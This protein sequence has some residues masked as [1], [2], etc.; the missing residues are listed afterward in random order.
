MPSLPLDATPSDTADD[1]ADHRLPSRHQPPVPSVSSS[2]QGAQQTYGSGL[3]AFRDAREIVRLVQCPSCSRLLQYPV[4]LPCGNS[5]CQQCLP[6][7]HKRENITY[8]N[9]P[10]RLNGFQCPFEGCRREHSLADCAV[11]IML[12][13]V[14]NIVEEVTA[15]ERTTADGEEPSGGE[16]VGRMA[17]RIEWVEK[18]KN[19]CEGRLAHAFAAAKAGQLSYGLDIAYAL[20]GDGAY[21]QRLDHQLLQRIKEKACPE[22]EC[23]VCCALLL[24]PVTTYC[25]HTFCRRCLER[26]LDHSQCCPTCRRTLQLPARLPAQSSNVHLTD[27]LVGL[28]PDLLAQRAAAVAIEEKAGSTE[29]SLETPI[30]VC[31]AS[32][33]GMPTPL[34]I[35]EPRYRLMVRRAWLGNR[36]FGMVLPNRSGE[37]QGELGI[38]SFM[39][40][41][42][43]LYMQYMDFKEDGR[44]NIWTVGVYKF[45]I[46]R[47]G[48]R[49]D[50]I[51]ADIDRLDDIPVTDE[52]AIEHM[53]TSLRVMPTSNSEPT[54]QWNQLSTQ[55]MLDFCHNFLH[56]PNARAQWLTPQNIMTFGRPPYDAAT[57]P[58]WLAAVMPV[59]EH[60]KYRLIVSTNVRERMKI[61]VSWIKTAESQPWYSTSNCVM[62]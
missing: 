38:T 46:R 34:H 25:G 50:Y 3:D 40:Y 54:S 57:L 47:W 33:P 60:E 27:I 48:L 51:V 58:Y 14:I 1:N 11:D 24:D 42:T 28:F 44:S 30:F 29:N 5:C 53:E 9:M 37:A 10:E 32:L 19:V 8:P 21:F 61:V 52:E 59:V 62:I 49:D 41:G 36:Q 45:E 39:K 15:A 43:M 20:P 12:M 7:T 26:V 17:V 4:A 31:A 23:Q 56:H 55:A 35:F 22:L 18:H 6:A 16:V 2:S 13:K